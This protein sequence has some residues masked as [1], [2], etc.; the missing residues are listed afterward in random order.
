MARNRGQN[1]EVGRQLAGV[2]KYILM[3]KLKFG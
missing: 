1:E 2:A 3:K